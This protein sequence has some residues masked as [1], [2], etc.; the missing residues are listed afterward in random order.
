MNK[1]A[2]ILINPFLISAYLSIIIIIFLPEIFSKYKATILDQSIISQKEGKMVHE[3][4]YGDGET[5]QI[6]LHYNELN[7]AALRISDYHNNMIWIL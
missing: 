7:N 5:G 4:L 3:D 2:T 1:L 6:I